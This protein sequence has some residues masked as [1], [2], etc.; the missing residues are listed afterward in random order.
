MLA[1]LFDFMIS[2]A[3]KAHATATA[4]TAVFSLFRALLFLFLFIQFIS[5]VFSIR[6]D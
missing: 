5:H 3:A 4:A 2:T 6:H 1:V